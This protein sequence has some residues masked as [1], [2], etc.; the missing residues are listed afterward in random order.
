MRGE[1]GR[2]RALANGL[3][4][5]AVLGLAG[6]GI[7]RISARQWRWQPTFS[8]RAEF[9]EIG[10]V[11]VGAKVRVQGIDA[12]VVEGIRPP[13]QPGRPVTLLLR[14]DARLRPLVR[15]DASAQVASQG[16][17]GARVVEITPGRPDAPPLPDGGVLRGEPTVEVADLL[18]DARTSLGRIDQATHAATNGLDEMHALVTSVRRGEGTLGKLIK[19]DEAYRRLMA[20]STRG[21]QT[22]VNLGENLEALKQTWPI[23]RYFNRRGFDDRDRVLYQPGSEREDRVLA[24]SDL[25]APGRAM[26]TAAGRTHLDEVARWFRATKRPATEVVIAAFTDEPRDEDL[27]QVLTQEQA[28]A[29]RNY[30]IKHHN[31]DAS[32]WFGHRK[33][34]AVGFG[35][36]VPRAREGTPPI[37]P[38]RRVEIILFTPQNT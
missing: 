37:S 31:I 2:G 13:S 25:F 12:G 4:V 18:R 1:I 26:L 32:G 36:Q 7:A 3:A 15:S 8:A 34:A 27:A 38:P 30:L 23:S 21:E 11:E 9:A 33:V 19:D 10:G 17:V 5:L 22:V 6:L 16:V 29:V 14:V 24:E 28:D 35:S 20:L